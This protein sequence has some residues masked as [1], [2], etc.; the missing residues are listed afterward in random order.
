M[1]PIQLIVLAACAAVAGGC[2]KKSEFE[3]LQH[4]AAETEADLNAQLDSEQAKSSALEQALAD[5]QAKV[6][7]FKEEVAA[8][9]AALTEAESRYASSLKDKA[10]LKASVDEM[11]AAL[12]SVE[13]QK[14][15]TEAR[16][17]E[18][19]AM[20]AKFQ[21]LID[22]GKLRV[23]IVDGR[24]VVELPSDILF[25]SGS[26]NLSKEGKEAIAETGQILAEMDRKFQVQGHT[27]DQPISTQRFPNNW[28]LASGRAIAVLEVLIEAGMSREKLSAAGYAD[29]VPAASNETKE[30]RAKNR[31]I[32]IAM[33]PDFS[34]LPGF[35]ELQSLGSP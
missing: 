19:R 14:K 7:V 23:K 6:A 18:Y 21:K 24:M 22:A 13:Q 4:R 9:K 28:A 25:A 12:R 31:R 2:V 1:R 16:V 5:E 33:V 32:E 30:G 35:E 34:E 3:A 27:D 8:L 15:R 10:K 26:V 29:V 20:L 17:A 11:Q